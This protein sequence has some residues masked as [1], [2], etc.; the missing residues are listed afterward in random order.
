[1][2]PQPAPRPTFVGALFHVLG[3]V[4]MVLLVAIGYVVVQAPRA[5]LALGVCWIAYRVGRLTWYAFRNDARLF[6]R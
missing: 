2:Q 5:V 3:V 6:A 1:M 4:G